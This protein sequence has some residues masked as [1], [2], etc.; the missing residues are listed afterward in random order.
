MAH[1]R[2]FDTLPR[3]AYHAFQTDPRR[4][5]WRLAGVDEEIVHETAK[6]AADEWTYHGD[7]GRNTLSV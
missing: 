2:F 1:N 6:G 4:V 3:R 5:D 7:L